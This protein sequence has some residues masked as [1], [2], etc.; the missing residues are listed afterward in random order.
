MRTSTGYISWEVYKDG[1][2]R[3]KGEESINGEGE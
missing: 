1:E 2:R 3:G